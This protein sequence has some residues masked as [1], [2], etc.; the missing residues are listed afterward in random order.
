MEL[1]AKNVE[2]IFMDCLFDEDTEE[3]RKKMIAVEGILS[4]FG[5]NPDAV[6]KHEKDIASML[7]QLPVQFQAKTG[8]GWSFLN[9]CDRAD[10][11]QWT[12]LHRTMEQLIVLGIASKWVKFSMPRS[13]WK[14]LP[15]GMPYF[16]VCEKR[17]VK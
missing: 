16:M 3:N 4:N 5:L 7:K 15:G 1:T 8:D 12:G 17:V 13:M 14:A 2:E 9:A 6:E 10:G 11:K